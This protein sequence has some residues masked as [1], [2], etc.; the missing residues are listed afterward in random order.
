MKHL[1]LS[2]AALLVVACSSATSQTTT[3]TLTWTHPTERVDGAALPAAEIRETVIA[4]GPKGGPYTQG[5]VTVPAPATTVQ[6]NRPQTPGTRCYVA[7]TVDTGNRSSVFSNEACKTIF[8]NP[9][10]P[11]GLTAG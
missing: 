7:Q 10:A 9:K 5:S 8:A 2:I 4:W 3:D 6:V 1:L 11:T